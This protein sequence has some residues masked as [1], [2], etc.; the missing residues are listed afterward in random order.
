M[1]EIVS[2]LL[3]EHMGNNGKNTL[4]NEPGRT[5]SHELLEKH[6]NMFANFLLKKGV[7]K[8]DRVILMCDL[9]ID[10]IIV[11]LG[12]MKIGAIYVPID[13]NQTKEMVDFI[14]KDIE[15]KCAFVDEK[16][17]EKINSSY[18]VK[19]KYSNKQDCEF[20][21]YL[22]SSD[23]KPNIRLISDDIVYITYTSGTTG[24]PKGVMISHKSIMTFMKYVTKNFKHNVNT[25]SLCRTPVS[26]D[27]F[28]TEV[29]PS[30][31]SGGQVY[32]QSRDVPFRKFLEYVCENKITNFGCGP[33]LLYILAD[34]LELF[35]RYNLS[36][37]EEIYIGYEKCP[38]NVIKILQKYLPKTDFING[39]GTTETFAS[40]TFYKIPN[41]GT[42]NSVEDIPIG[43]AIEN[44]ELLIINDQL[45]ICE[46]NEIGE[47]V[48]RGSSLFNGYWKNIIE[49]QKKLR[50][51]PIFENS[52][53]L[54]YFTGDLVKRKDDGHIYFVGRKDEQVKINGYRVELGEIKYVIELNEKIKECVILFHNKHLICIYNSYDGNVIDTNVLK[55]ICS[56]RLAKYKIPSK[57]IFCKEIPRNSNGKVNRKMLLKT[58][59]NEQNFYNDGE[60]SDEK[61][62]SIFCQE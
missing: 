50:I 7:K 60:T 40:S 52:N 1:K 36:C 39:Y 46:N 58:I 21:S 38:V 45:K 12:I 61:S 48:I 53:E 2:D 27:P 17:Y 31:I 56:K 42:D 62:K 33:S 23:V 16:Y 29:I 54:V 15:P 43:E 28:L 20:Y 34:N 47:L 8:N 14:M 6:S 10:T 49:T 41:L 13:V 57:W 18:C 5:M 22:K 51:N 9:N 35:K 59:E 25:K 55:E 11:V 44:E 26:F 19:I 3:M 32:I 24:I 37:L 4:L 30:I